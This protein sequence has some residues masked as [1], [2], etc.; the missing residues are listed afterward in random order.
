LLIPCEVATKSVVPAVRAL[1]AKVLVDKRSLNQDQ[2]AEVLGISQSA[3]SKYTRNVRGYT[4]KLDDI[5]EIEPI[6]NKI[7]DML[8]SRTYDRKE[9]LDSFCTACMIIRAKRL[10]CKYCKQS[11]SNL[12][13]KNCAF[14]PS[15]NPLLQMANAAAMEGKI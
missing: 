12:I 9:L 4:V 13:T 1:I 7:A 11:D 5:R 15:H 2:A 14:C 6:I 3:V 10:M 8:I